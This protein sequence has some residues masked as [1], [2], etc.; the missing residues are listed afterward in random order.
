MDH[1]RRRF[2]FGAIG[3]GVALIAL[4]TLLVPR[5]EDL[6]QPVPGGGLAAVPPLFG[7]GVV[8]P[9]PYTPEELRGPL[10][11]TWSI[12][13]LSDATRSAIAAGRAFAASL[14]IE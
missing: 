13:E 8:D 3:L 1:G 14:A 2:L 9:A 11:A 12:F 6:R 10:G 7:G 5:H 4:V